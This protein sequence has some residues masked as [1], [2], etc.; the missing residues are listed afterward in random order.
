MLFF[1]C[2]YYLL[3]IFLLYIIYL[4]L[5]LFIFFIWDGVGTKDRLFCRGWGKGV[6]ALIRKNT[7]ALVGAGHYNPGWPEY[8]GSILIWLAGEGM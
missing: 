7:G 4:L 3:C 5:L 2:Y 1:V 6:E 8:L